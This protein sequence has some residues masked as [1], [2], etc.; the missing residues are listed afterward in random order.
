MA[1]RTGQP[2]IHAM[3]GFKSWERSGDR[4][5]TSPTKGRTL[6]TQCQQEN[7]ICDLCGAYG[8]RKFHCDLSAKVFNI[9]H[10]MKTLD[11]KYKAKMDDFFKTAQAH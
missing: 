3:K 10:N 2:I 4:P 11:P 5:K 7:V 1:E 8:H 9:L 6:P